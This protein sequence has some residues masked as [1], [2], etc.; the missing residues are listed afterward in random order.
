MVDEHEYDERDI[1]ILPTA[2]QRECVAGAI[3]ARTGGSNLKLVS[4]KKREV[5]LDEVQLPAEIR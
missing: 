1:R 4:Q 3:C 5:F 2:E